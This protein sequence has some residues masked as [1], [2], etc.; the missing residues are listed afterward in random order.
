MS[1]AAL[2]LR[3]EFK[4]DLVP[5]LTFADRNVEDPADVDV[6][7]RS[8][9][10][11]APLAECCEAVARALGSGKKRLAALTEDYAGLQENVEEL[12]RT[13]RWTAERGARIRV[14]YVLEDD[15]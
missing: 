5:L 10:D 14:T 9:Q 7:E 15:A 11:A 4:I 12:G 2:V 3:G 6:L 13:A 1:L 8:W